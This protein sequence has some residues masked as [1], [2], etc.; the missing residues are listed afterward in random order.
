MLEHIWDRRSPSGEAANAAPDGDRNDGPRR[1]GRVEALT[2]ARPPARASESRS[3]TPPATSPRPQ[4]SARRPGGGA[5]DDDATA[6]AEDKEG[7]RLVVGARIDLKG[8]VSNCDAL[9]V[10]GHLEG[11]AR[12]RILQ[13]AQ[14]GTFVGDAEVEIAE[15]S[16]SIQGTLTVSGNLIIRSTGRVHGTIRYYAVQIEPGGQL[17]GDVQ[18]TADSNDAPRPAATPAASA[19]AGAPVPSAR[20]GS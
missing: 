6:H 15:V 13:V 11:S 1:N 19:V 8:E 4:G 2:A 9:I 17:A 16:G 20:T 7:Q 5:P 3:A 14:G 18:V 10:Q 12:S